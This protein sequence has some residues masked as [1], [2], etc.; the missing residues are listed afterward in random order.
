MYS[1]LCFNFEPYP[2]PY[3]LNNISPTLIQV[4]GNGRIM[5]D[6]RVVLGGTE[7]I[8]VSQ[9]RNNLITPNTYN[10]FLVHITKP[11]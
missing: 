10:I 8:N 4:R 1:L 3:I 6:F 7:A 2:K 11:Q 9:V 5:D